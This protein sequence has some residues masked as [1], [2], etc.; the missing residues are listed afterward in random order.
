M[1]FHE[2]HI[3]ILLNPKYKHLRPYLA[4]IEEHFEREGKEIYRDRNVLR[5]LCVDGLNIC[6]KRYAQLSLRSQMAVNFYK[7]PKGKKAYIKPLELRERGFE[8]PE[9]IAF[10]KYRRGLIH[11]T[12]YFVCLQ[13]TYRYSLANILSFELPERDEITRSFAAYA[14]RLHE[15]GFLHRDLTAADVLFDKVNDRYHFSLI[16]TNSMHTGRTV[17][18]ERGCANL[19]R[20]VGDDHFFNLLAETYAE[21][22]NVNPGFCLECFRKARA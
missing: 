6:V 10:V 16:D 15:E 21:R 14:A 2:P 8:S 12:T 7:S 5:T 1:T 22:R 11:V 3:R 13:S 4:N 19:A 9:P 17:S 18:V 20:L